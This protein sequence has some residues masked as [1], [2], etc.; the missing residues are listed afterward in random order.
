MKYIKFIIIAVLL[1]TAFTGCSYVSDYVEGAITDRASFSVQAEFIAGTGVQLSWDKTD[2]GGNFAGIEIYRTS[3][4]NDEYANYTL[5][6]SRY[7]DS[8]LA[9]GTTK[10]YIDTAPPSGTYF[11][12]VGLIHWDKDTNERTAANGYIPAYEIPG[13]DGTTNYNAHTDLDKV[14]GYGIVTIP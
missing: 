5:I 12:R 14:S 7:S 13:W 4:E 10:T 1:N 9:I 3:E 2:T 8:S 6:A 11:Y